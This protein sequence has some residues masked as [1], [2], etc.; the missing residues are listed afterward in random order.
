MKGERRTVGGSDPLDRVVRRS[1]FAI[2]LESFTRAFWPLGSALAALWAAL[3][4]GLAEVA[5]R[6]Q[7]I[8]LLGVAGAGI[9]VLLVLGLRR[10]RWPR[11]ED[12]RDRIDATL[13]GRP[14]ATLRDRP[15]LGRDD[16]A[17]EAVWAAHLARM[18]RL[19]ATA[20]PVLADLRLAAR[21]PWAL[22]LMALVALLAALVF[23][24]DRGVESVA[25]ALQA[26]PAA[27]TAAGPSYEGWAEP[28]AYTGRPTLYLPEVPGD[29]PVAVPQGTVVTLRAYGD[30]ERFE[31]AE[32]VSG[33]PP[34]AL[35]E[36]APGIASATFP[37]AANG[38]VTLD[39][40]GRALGSWSFTMEPDA[41]PTIAMI[42][43]LERTATGE[44]RLAYE[45]KDDHGVVAARAEIALD[46]GRVERRFGLAVEP[47]LPP[48]LTA[49]LPQ[50]MTGDAD[51]LAETL[52]EDF[53]KHP[54]AGLPVTVTL[55]AEDAIGQT[56]TSGRVEAV[57]PMRRFYDPLAQALIEQRR[58][59]LWST[60]N[61]RRVTQVLR[62]VTYRPEGLF[63]SPRAYLVVRTAIRR[64]D[65]AEKADGVGAV[66]DEIAEALWQA[67]VQ[68][69]D[70]DL[71]NAAER[72]ARAKERLQE[73][74][75]SD[76]TDE[77]IARLM[78]ELRQATR[79]YMQE[80]ARRAIEN[81]E[82]Q[83]AEIP[84]G[85]MMTQDQ[86]QEL[87]D[88][89]QELS[90][91]GR[92]AE[93]EALLEMLQQMLENMQMMMGQQGEGQG[94]GGQGQQSMQGLADALRE[95]QGLADEAFRQLQEE[96]RR[97]RG[98]PGP[99]TEGGRPGD[100]L[101]QGDSRSL[102]E[103][104]EALRQ[105]MEELQEGLPGAAGEAAR[106]ALREAERNMGAA[107]DDLES[108]DTGDALDRQA[109]AIDQL[110]EGMREMGEDLR[111]A[112]NAQGGS[113]QG[114]IAGETSSET[115]RD[116]LGRP[117]G[118]RGSVGSNENIVPDADSAS[119]ARALLDEIRRRSGEQG[120]PQLELDY[121][122]RLLD[123]F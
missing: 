13:P 108:G 86:I 101:G 76:A 103:R 83:Q 57:L 95:Q 46:A 113:E 18:R 115:G 118:S 91:Q 36:A 111:R 5:S 109:D 44:T 121:L 49:D 114:Q 48:S 106:E 41:A 32:T 105:L 9:A 112:E 40:G 16:P 85:Q 31:L 107:R 93:A 25:A 28:P 47:Q 60:A 15:A 66:R 80:M 51:E 23:A 87:M 8:A 1:R 54:L 10:F 94:E 19:A 71:G 88:R 39:Q 27:A 4:F 116:P 81:G 64:L 30:T 68:I 99:G 38:T 120:R 73:A 90:E 70:G 119:R 22:R 97:G 11:V 92:R 72:L 26:P 59:L 50:P 29:A 63:D 43:S 104:Q 110:R 67:A 53:S 75:R 55:V 58:D 78:D 7:L 65:A 14:L 84:P 102:A 20:K 61:A 33:G 69:E 6:G 34:A 42:G 117:I 123:W 35:A 79:D 82:M 74:L 62:A 21:D 52:V 24:R 56:G 12:A 45:A 3:A 37:V 17:A 98:D 100:E 122:R 77:E 96:F 89:I 2:G